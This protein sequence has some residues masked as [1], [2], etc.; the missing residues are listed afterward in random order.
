MRLV[1]LL[2]D[3]TRDRIILRWATWVMVRFPRCNRQLSIKVAFIGSC[4]SACGIASAAGVPDRP[5]NGGWHLSQK[6][7][8]TRVIRQSGDPA[9]SSHPAPFNHF[10][11]NQRMELGPYL[12]FDGIDYECTLCER[13]FASKGSLYAHCRNTSRHEWCERC[14]RV[15]ISTASKDAHFKASGR[16]NFCVRCPSSRDFET[17]DELETHLTEYHYFCSDCNLYHQSAEELREHDIDVHNLCIKC[18]RY[19]VNKNNFEMV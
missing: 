4:R 8:I 14:C 9:F 13:L 7:G 10:T 3:R 15:F 16:H 18:E 19:F 1:T 2:L 5:M 12:T 11:V 6:A 17:L